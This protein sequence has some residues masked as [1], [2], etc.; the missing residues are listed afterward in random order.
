MLVLLCAKYL[1]P[2]AHDDQKGHN[3]IDDA[4]GADCDCPYNCW[5]VDTTEMSQ[6]PSYLK[7]YYTLG[8]MFR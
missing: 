2:I 6:A 7:H 1:T 5:E 3:N 8:R 4:Q